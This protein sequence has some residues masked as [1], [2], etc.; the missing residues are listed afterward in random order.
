M[1]DWTKYDISLKLLFDNKLISSW[2]L[3]VCKEICKYPTLHDAIVFY[4]EHGKFIKV[5]YCGIATNNELIKMCKRP[6]VI[7]GKLNKKELVEM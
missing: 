6:S 3:T 2:A 7:L 4:K 1:R 5:R